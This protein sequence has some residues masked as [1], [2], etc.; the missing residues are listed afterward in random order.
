MSLTLF[1]M[2]VSFFWLLYNYQ[3]QNR[4][5]IGYTTVLSLLFGGVFIC[6]L[7]GPIFFEDWSSH[8]VLTLLV[9]I[10]GG[11]VIY[12]TSQLTLAFEKIRHLSQNSGLESVDKNRL[13]PDPKASD[14]PQGETKDQI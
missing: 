8:N 10:L 5:Y 4:I 3:K 14:S 6:A 12:L 13:Q 11:V 9:W 2:L 7:L 1:I